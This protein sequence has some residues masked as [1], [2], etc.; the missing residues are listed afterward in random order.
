M[1]SRDH[2]FVAG[3]EASCVGG[4][5]LDVSTRCENLHA[6]IG[7]QT[8]L[9]MNPHDA[10]LRLH[11]NRVAVLRGG[12]DRGGNDRGGNDRGGDRGD[13]GGYRRDEY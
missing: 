13:R 7:D 12:N 11:L 9:H 10:G 3:G 2:H 4:R 5:P 1:S 6:G 8:D